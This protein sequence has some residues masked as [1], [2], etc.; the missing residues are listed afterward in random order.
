M[1]LAERGGEASSKRYD[2]LREDKQKSHQLKETA[3]NS[4]TKVFLFL[5][6]TIFLIMLR[7]MSKWWLRSRARRLLHLK[8]SLEELI[9]THHLLAQLLVALGE[10]FVGFLQLLTFLHEQPVAFSL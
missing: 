2:V 5:C 1:K 7:V 8:E 3:T 10:Q 4:I 9:E 6:L